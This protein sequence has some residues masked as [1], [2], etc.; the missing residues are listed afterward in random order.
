MKNKSNINFLSDNRK[1]VLMIG[2]FYSNAIRDLSFLFE[3][4]PDRLKPDHS[5]GNKNRQAKAFNFIT[6]EQAN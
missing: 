4:Y 1:S 5:T 3:L 2:N 6:F